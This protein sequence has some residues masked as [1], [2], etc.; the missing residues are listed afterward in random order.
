MNFKLFTAAIFATL[1]LTGCSSEVSIEKQTKLVEYQVCLSAESEQWNMAL[2]KGQIQ[3][4]LKPG[5]KFWI[6]SENRPYQV[7]EFAQS[8]CEQYKP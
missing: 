2:S 5:G 7:F 8:M 1:L 3:T 6:E 4:E